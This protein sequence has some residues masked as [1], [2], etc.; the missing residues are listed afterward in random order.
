M[1]ESGAIDKP[2]WEGAKATPVRLEDSLRGDEPH[3]QYFKEQVRRELVARFGWETVYQGGLNVFSTI[4][5]KMQQA[6]ETAV[7]DQ[8]KD[9]DQRRARI[10]AQRA[11]SGGS[12]DPDSEPL[13]AALMAMD[14]HSGEVRAMVGGRDFGQSHFNRAVQAKR[15]PGSAFKPFVY[16]APSKPGSRRRPS[17]IV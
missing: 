6:A 7:A 2:T 1:L 14:P 3:G 5:M 8:L 17:S 11:R 16:A 12:P 15:Q 10:A 9:L 4:D 13:Q